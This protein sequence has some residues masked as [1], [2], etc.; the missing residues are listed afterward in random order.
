MKKNPLNSI[1]TDSREKNCTITMIGLYVKP[2]R[3]W[4]KEKRK[5]NSHT[6]EKC[7]EKLNTISIAWFAIYIF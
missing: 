3:R 7:L 2:Q 1:I 5:K 6:F 4:V